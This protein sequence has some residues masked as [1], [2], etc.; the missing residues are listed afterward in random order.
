MS[1]NL[2]LRYGFPDDSAEVVRLAALDS[3]EPP[4]APWLLAEVDGELRAVL[5]LST[6]AHV[7]DPFH[8]TSELLELLR[9]RS[10]QLVPAPGGSRRPRLARIH[11]GRPAWR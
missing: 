11:L 4:P 3:A 5:S 2:T 10:R 6:C 9:T 7:A 1:N 8:S